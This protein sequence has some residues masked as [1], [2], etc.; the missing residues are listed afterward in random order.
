MEPSAREYTWATL[1]LEDI[2]T[3][4]WPSIHPIPEGY[5]YMDLSLQVGG[6][7]QYLHLEMK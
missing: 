6:G 5:I 2:N 7:L 4:T 3:G 1:F